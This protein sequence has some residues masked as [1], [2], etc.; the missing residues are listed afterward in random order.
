MDLAEWPI[1]RESL[2]K[3]EESLTR[4]RAKLV[5]TNNLLEEEIR[6]REY[7]A[8]L[9]ELYEIYEENKTHIERVDVLLK[10]LCF[11][12]GPR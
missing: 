7:S 4:R 3:L 1:D 6:S 8:E 10:E 9:R 5:E 11:R 12:L 2:D